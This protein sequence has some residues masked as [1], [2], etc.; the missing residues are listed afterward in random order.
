MDV[1]RTE[2]PQQRRCRPP[3]A[4]SWRTQRPSPLGRWHHHP[5]MAR[6]WQKLWVPHH[7]R[8][9]KGSLALLLP[10]IK[11][12]ARQFA[13]GASAPFRKGEKA[14]PHLVQSRAHNWHQEP[15][16]DVIHQLL[17]DQRVGHL[18][19][20]GAGVRRGAQPRPPREGEAAQSCWGR[21]TIPQ[22]GQLPLPQA[23]PPIHQG[24]GHQNGLMFYLWGGGARK[25]DR[26]PM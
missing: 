2:G 18:Q 24:G 5:T 22:E 6:L 21:P 11:A 13:Q 4:C 17:L 3:E 14:H 9:P 26:G 25:V 15:I 23:A 1:W 20:K 12:H 19:G 7:T 10:G 16:V 8:R